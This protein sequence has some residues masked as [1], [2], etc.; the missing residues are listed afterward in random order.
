MSLL[1]GGLAGCS[2]PTLIKQSGPERH[3]LILVPDPAAKERAPLEGLGPTRTL[4]TDLMMDRQSRRLLD[5]MT[6]DHFLELAVIDSSSIGTLEN[7]PTPPS[8]AV[9][10]LIPGAWSLTSAPDGSVALKIDFDFAEACL[11]PEAAVSSPPLEGGVLVA[12]EIGP[13]RIVG[14]RVVPFG[15][16]LDAFVQRRCPGWIVG[17]ATLRPRSLAEAET[18]R[19]GEI[20]G[21]VD[22]GRRLWP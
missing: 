3:E 12:G 11:V 13:R 17:V 22:Y 4:F 7:P 18:W 5:H 2:S 20:A 9:L 10:R 15:L 19:Q 1:A 21:Q 8:P 14:E 16:A 6:G